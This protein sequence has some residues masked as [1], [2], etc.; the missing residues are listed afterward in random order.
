MSN[1]EVV[2]YVPP[3]KNIAEFTA[4][5]V[6]LGV[7]LALV[8]CAAN[9]YLGL[10]VGMTVSA[11]IPAAV[12]SMGLL[13]GLLRRG[14]ILENNIV[15]TIASTGESLAAGIIFTVPALVLAGVWNTFHFW[16]TVTIALLGGFFGVLFM[17]PLRRA[18]IIEEKELTFPEGVAC[19]E[20]LK[21][22]EEK[23]IG[24]LFI[25]WAMVIG[26][27]FKFLVTAMGFMKEA[28]E[29][30][31]MSTTGAVYYVGTNVSPLLIAVGYIVGL[32]VATLVFL[33]GV[34]GWVI[35]I[36]IYTAANP[37]TSGTP[38][39]DVAWSA[40]STQIRY[41]GVGAMV[42]GG[43][44][45]IFSIRHGIVDSIRGTLAGLKRGVGEGEVV[46]RT[47]MDLEFPYVWKILIILVILTA[48]FYIILTN[49]GIGLVSTVLMVIAAFFFVAVASYIV[50]LV[51]SSNSPVSGMTICTL[52]FVSVILLLFGMKGES[53]ILAALGI[54]GVV[55]C[56][57]CTSGDICQDLKTG[58]LVGATPRKQQ[59]AEFI[60]AFFPAFIIPP[61]LIVLHSGYGIGTAARE[62]VEPL[63]APQ[64]GLFAS[65]TQ[66]LF[67]EGEKLPWIMFYSGLIV[68]V[69]IVILDE[70]LRIFKAPFRLYVMAVAVG[71][72]LPLELSVP[73]FIGGLIH[74]IVWR[75]TVAR[76]FKVAFDAI[77]R[78]ILFASGLIAGEAIMGIIL[79]IPLTFGV[80]MPF[81]SIGSFKISEMPWLVN[82]LTIILPLL[83]II[84]FF[85]VSLRGSKEIQE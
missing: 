47:E 45:S 57:A 71:I 56:A 15:Q 85:I 63:M 10:K 51:G 2:P 38:A 52:L 35:G 16:P 84:G 26:L 9:T 53:G 58:Y 22:G 14:T 54:A 17:I 24:F 34:I 12:I 73:I 18:L 68:G 66:M 36:P 48:I 80:M 79:A 40:W 25:I 69:I 55:C 72:Y 67:G 77:H 60:G 39:L 11:S 4:Q 30:A 23:G 62:G 27:V 50:G 8:M 37:D 6:I 13:R 41:M 78:G 32:N 7:I 33:G 46:K 59:I 28:V 5:S 65:I 1:D 20:V 31:R 49:L 3:E 70:I 21:V 61:I 81:A 44:W 83:V 19:A 64:A 43:L 42:V 29:A 76:G 74:L 75:L 82:W